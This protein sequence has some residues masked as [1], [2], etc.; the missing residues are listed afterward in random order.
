MKED[1]I[2]V[3]AFEYWYAT[4]GG[5]TGQAVS[6]AVTEKCGVSQR[7]FWNWYK[8]F[9]WKARAIERNEALA[10]KLA[11]AVI[12]ET[13]KTREELLQIVHLCIEEFEQNLRTGRVKILDVADFDKLLKLHQLLVGER[14]GDETTINIITAIPRPRQEVD[15]EVFQNGTVQEVKI[16]LPSHKEE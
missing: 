11:E 14:T 7:T 10:D 6:R 8:R 2:H 5:S 4:G 12:A 9:N 16:E 13:L 1:R 3:K 15:G